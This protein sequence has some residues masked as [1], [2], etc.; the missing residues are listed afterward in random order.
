M[1]SAYLD[2]YLT[3]DGLC[4]WRLRRLILTVRALRLAPFD[5]ANGKLK[6]MEI[7]FN[8]KWSRNANA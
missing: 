6:A 1:D 5:P 7:L 2:R 8:K 4:T 3:E